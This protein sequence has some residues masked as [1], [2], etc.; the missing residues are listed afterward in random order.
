MDE[1]ERDITDIISKV[2]NEFGVRC[3]LAYSPN[4]YF[5]AFFGDDTKVGEATKYFSEKAKAYTIVPPAVIN[6]DDSELKRFADACSKDPNILTKNMKE[7]IVGLP[8][9]SGNI[10]YGE[11]NKKC[12][13][14][15]L[16]DDMGQRNFRNAVARAN[17]W[18]R[19]VGKR[20]KRF[21][22]RRAREERKWS[23]ILPD[24]EARD[25]RYV[26][27]SMVSYCKKKGLNN[28]VGLDR[29]GRP[30][31]LLMRQVWEKLYG[32]RPSTYFLE[33]H[34]LNKD[35]KD[36]LARLKEQSPHLY[37]GLEE[38]PEKFVFVDD[39]IWLGGG[40]SDLEK[41]SKDI[42]GKEAEYICMSSVFEHRTPSW[43]SQREYIGVSPPGNLGLVSAK[44]KGSQKEINELRGKLKKISDNV[45]RGRWWKKHRSEFV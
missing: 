37:R 13:L 22:D 33:P 16:R 36:R 27:P 25:L 41:L 42:G 43:H 19:T 26:I 11:V 2:E 1:Y 38:N 23:G 30:V 4:N 21:N 39:Q 31:A 9:L 18:N 6:L 24:I 40:K 29:S 45:K 7:N 12:M 20:Q 3:T 14:S 15:Y 8:V 44:E 34:S 35:D 5:A 10:I 17:Y 28:I 32:E